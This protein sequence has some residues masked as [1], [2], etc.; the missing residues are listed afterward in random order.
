M[1]RMSL[2]VVCRLLCFVYICDTMRYTIVRLSIIQVWDRAI[3][4]ERSW[5]TVPHLQDYAAVATAARRAIELRGP[6]M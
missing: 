2:A 6:L 4:S 1:Y 3:G 5:T